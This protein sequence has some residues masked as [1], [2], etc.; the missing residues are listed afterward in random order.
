[1]AAP[2]DVVVIEPVPLIADVGVISVDG[3][4]APSAP[5]VGVGV[6]GGTTVIGAGVGVGGS[7][8]GVVS[9]LRR[10]SA[11]VFAMT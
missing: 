2:G 8:G 7:T 5:G 4:A 10:G 9:Q 3:V 11:T 6:A 1:L